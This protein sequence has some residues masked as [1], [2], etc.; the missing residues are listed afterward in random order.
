[1]REAEMNV[2]KTTHRTNQSGCHRRA[3]TAI[4]SAVAWAASAAALRT[5]DTL[6]ESTEPG[7][8]GPVLHE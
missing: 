2:V 8:A 6:D 4:D 5:F 1:M 7:Q 3:N